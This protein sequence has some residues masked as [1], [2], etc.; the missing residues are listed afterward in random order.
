MGRPEVAVQDDLPRRR[1]TMAF[2]DR[3][4]TRLGSVVQ[5]E[6]HGPAKSCSRQIGI[7][8]AGPQHC[9]SGVGERFPGLRGVATVLPPRR[10]RPIGLRPE[11]TQAFATARLCSH[12]GP[13]PSVGDNIALESPIARTSAVVLISSYPS[14]C[15]AGHAH[16]PHAV[17]QT[18][19]P[20]RTLSIDGL[21]VSALRQ[22]QRAGRRASEPRTEI[23]RPRAAFA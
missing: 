4:G 15:L 19:R 14:Q 8:V 5:R 10:L 23:V 11:S 3:T 12:D 18:L 2:D 16:Q 21:K 13:A 6:E 22:Q 20:C 7:Q 17:A 1:G 9:D